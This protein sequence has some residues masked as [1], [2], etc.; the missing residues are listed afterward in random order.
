MNQK[1]TMTVGPI[2][3]INEGESFVQAGARAISVL[4]DEHPSFGEGRIISESLA[5]EIVAQDWDVRIGVIVSRVEPFDEHLEKIRRLNVDFVDVNQGLIY[6]SLRAQL[7]DALDNEIV[8]SGIGID[9]DEDPEWTRVKLLNLTA[10]KVLGESSFVVSIVP[11]LKMGLH[12]LKHEA[13][14]FDEDLKVEDIIAISK[15]FPTLVNVGG[16]NPSSYEWFFRLL[17]EGTG[18]AIYLSEG[19][20][21]SAQVPI[22]VEPKAGLRILREWEKVRQSS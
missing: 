7:G 17:P 5:Q 12:F 11:S 21:G 2:A 8:V 19:K 3:S 15:E 6:P 14:E 16:D 18:L 13:G 10:G 9:Y 4:I 20:E 1:T 22:C